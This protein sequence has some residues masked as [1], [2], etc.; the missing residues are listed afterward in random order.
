MTVD[1]DCKR[2]RRRRRGQTR[3]R[4]R[5]S[6][7]MNRIAGEGLRAHPQEG[8]RGTRAIRSDML[9]MRARFMD[10]RDGLAECWRAYIP[11]RKSTIFIE[12]RVL[13]KRLA[14]KRGRVADSCGQPAKAITERSQRRS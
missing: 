8:T 5:F 12:T 2:W 9:K 10:V 3:S 14:Q 11:R 7:A 4:N 13:W 6:I 1:R